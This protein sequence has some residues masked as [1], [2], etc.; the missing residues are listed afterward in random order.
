VDEEEVARLL[1]ARARAWR[2]ARGRAHQGR[3]AAVAARRRWKWLPAATALVAT[4]L[5]SAG[6]AG[7]ASGPAPVREALAPVGDRVTHSW[8]GDAPGRHPSAAPTTGQLIPP[9]TISVSAESTQGPK[10]IPPPAAS[11]HPQ[12]SA[13]PKKEVDQG[14]AS[15]DQR[16]PSHS[17]SPHPD[18]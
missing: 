14:R 17:P 11:P 2:G 9:S 5:F 3:W 10:A 18:D 12:T 1:R 8:R 13:T 4:A 15:G 7:Y 6:A 16:R